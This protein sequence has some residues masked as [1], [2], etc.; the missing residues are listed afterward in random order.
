MGVASINL[1]DVLTILPWRNLSTCLSSYILHK[2]TPQLVNTYLTFSIWARDF[3]LDK[4]N[5]GLGVLRA[6][7]ALAKREPR[8]TTGARENNRASQDFLVL[9]Y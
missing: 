2:A 4:C 7:T 6:S 1:V 9:T 8:S 3:D 5:L